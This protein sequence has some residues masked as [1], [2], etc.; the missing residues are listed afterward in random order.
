[1]SEYLHPC[2][3]NSAVLRARRRSNCFCWLY[4]LDVLFNKT[5]IPTTIDQHAL[6][7]VRNL[8]APCLL[9]ACNDAVHLVHPGSVSLLKRLLCF[10]CCLELGLRLGLLLRRLLRLR[11]CRIDSCGESCYDDV[12]VLCVDFLLQELSHLRWLSALRCHVRADAPDLGCLVL[13]VRANCLV[14]MAI[15]SACSCW[16]SASILGCFGTGSSFPL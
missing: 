2:S 9:A 1:M 14:L 8:I 5:L 16:T 12:H 10:A 3:T 7:L 13:D 15:P 6:H 4:V 11:N